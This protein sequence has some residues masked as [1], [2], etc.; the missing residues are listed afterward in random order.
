MEKEKILKLISMALDVQLKGV[1]INGFPYIN[2]ECGNYSGALCI[3]ILD[4]GFSRNPYDGYY[5][6]NI[7]GPYSSRLYSQCISHLKE[8][9]ERV[10]GFE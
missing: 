1:G 6:F 4:A 7:H 2:V 10:K 8:L 5:E 3:K 9:G